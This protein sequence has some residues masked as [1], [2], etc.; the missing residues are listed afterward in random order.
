M[1]TARFAQPTHVEFDPVSVRRLIADGQAQLIDVREPQERA[2]LFVQGSESM[3]LSAFDPDKIPAN[4]DKLTIL[5]CHGGTRSRKA[6]DRA[7][8]GAKGTFAHMRGGIQAWKAAGLPVVESPSFSL[9]PMQQTQV[10]MG[11]LVL[12]GTLLGAFVTPW[13]LIL[14]GFIACGMIYAG[15]SGNCA[16]ANLLASFPWNQTK[17]APAACKI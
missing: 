17:T 8:A 15:V 10:L 9:T 12:S 6:L 1:K 11:L 5:H 2:R 3:P 13:A 14:S 4:A 16:M 7:L